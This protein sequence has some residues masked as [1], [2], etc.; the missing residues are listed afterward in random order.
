MPI[1]FKFNKQKMTLYGALISPVTLE[2]FRDVLKKIVHSPDFPPDIRTLWDLRKLDFKE[3]NRHVE[4]SLIELKK[5]FPQR[6]E[7]K[8]AFIVADSLAFGMTRMY[9]IMA[10]DLPQKT[11]VFLNYSEGEQWLLDS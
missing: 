7:A 1:E 3:I 6:G 9:E 8:L 11:R 2:E 5:Q 4:E 10:D